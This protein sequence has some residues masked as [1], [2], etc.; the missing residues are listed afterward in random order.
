MGEQVAACR[1]ASAPN[2]G[3]ARQHKVGK[4]EIMGLLTA[5][6]RSLLVAELA[7]Q[8]FSSSRLLRAEAAGCRSQCTR[9]RRTVRH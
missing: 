5:G 7:S 3:P 9:L 6:E 1:A 2:G 8:P 4:E